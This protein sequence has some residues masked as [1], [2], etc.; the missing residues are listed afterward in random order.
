MNTQYKPV[1][2][3][4]LP[5]IYEMENQVY[6]ALE[7]ISKSGWKKFN[8]S[9]LEYDWEK[10]HPTPPKTTWEVGT[11]SHSILLEGKNLQDVIIRQPSNIINRTTSKPGAK[12]KTKWEDFRDAQDPKMVIMKDADWLKVNGIVEAGRAHPRFDVL[13]TGGVAEQSFFWLNEKYGFTQ[14]CRPDYLPGLGVVTSLKTTANAHPWPFGK[15]AGDLKYHWSA[16]L[17]LHGV[18]LL[19]GEP[20]TEYNIMVIEQEPPHQ[21]VVYQ[22]YPADIDAGRQQLE[23][24]YPE[25]SKC[26]LDDVWPGYED[27]LLH[28][29]SYATYVDYDMVDDD[30]INPKQFQD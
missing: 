27:G 21:C 4:N 26:L 13:L 24:L 8:I 11:V 2:P 16:H 29:P 1:D 18:S 12:N 19:T 17:E 22:H 23:I 3:I 9:P 10:K 15:I 25:Y 6:H 5:G 28:M 14:K 7:G 30:F 20:H